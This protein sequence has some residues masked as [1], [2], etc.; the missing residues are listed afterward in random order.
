MAKKKEKR[1]GI[2][3]LHFEDKEGKLINKSYEID[4]TVEV[5]AYTLSA[6]LVLVNSMAKNTEFSINYVK[7]S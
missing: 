7:E 3:T 1:E 4:S 6:A 2:L 5:A